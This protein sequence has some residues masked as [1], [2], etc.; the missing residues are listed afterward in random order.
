MRSDTGRDVAEIFIAEDN[1]A[2]VYLIR[3]ALEDRKLLH[4]LSVAEDGEQAAE[5]LKRAGKDGPCPDLILLDLNLPRQDGTEL[6]Q[7]LREHP[8]CGSKPVIV[9]SSSDS[10][11]DYEFALRMDATFFRK[12]ADLEAFMRIADLIME[13]L[14]RMA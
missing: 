6:L 12:P 13:K 1:R 7:K 11:K 8:H 10:P 4:H 9:I 2:D 14:P 5:F 3:K